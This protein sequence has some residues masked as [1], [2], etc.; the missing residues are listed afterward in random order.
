MKYLK[1]YQLF[2]SAD[3][4]DKYLLNLSSA[5]SMIS[6]E[7][8]IS[9]YSNVSDVIK[10][11]AS[12]WS[13]YP[14]LNKLTRIPISVRNLSNNEIAN[15]IKIRGIGPMRLGQEYDEEVFLSKD[16][17]PK[18]HKVFGKFKRLPIEKKVEFMAELQSEDYV[19]CTNSDIIKIIDKKDLEYELDMISSKFQYFL[20]GE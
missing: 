19:F 14:M 17:F 4:N 13:L 12:S 10:R 3:D 16:L 18:F 5:N 8:W 6:S 11:G 1:S 15:Q 20:L 7:R 2:E 9:D